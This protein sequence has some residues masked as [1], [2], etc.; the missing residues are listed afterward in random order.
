M[1]PRVKVSVNTAR[2]PA[3]GCV[4]LTLSLLHRRARTKG[5]GERLKGVCLEKAVQASFP[6]SR[7]K[8]VAKPLYRL[9]GKNGSGRGTMVTQSKSL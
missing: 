1:W 5:R 6:S 8:D 9:S 7:E 2:C 4:C 3:G